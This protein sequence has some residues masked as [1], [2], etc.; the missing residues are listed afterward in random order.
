MEIQTLVLAPSAR[1][2][3]GILFSLKEENSRFIVLR[4]KP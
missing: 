1:S 2:E 3:H 4:G